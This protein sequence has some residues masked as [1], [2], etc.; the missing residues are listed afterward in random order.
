MSPGAR[1]GGLA[2]GFWAAARD[3]LYPPVCAACGEE[4]GA[5]AA[6][7]PACFRETVFLAPPLC[8]VC[9]A[10]APADGGAG[11]CDACLHAP[12][13][14]DRARAAALYAGPARRAALQLKHGDRLD[15]A[16]AVAP[17]LAR[18]GE[19]ML[20]E[21]DVIA[22]VPLHWTRLA[23]R[24]FNQAAELGRAA[25]RAAG[26]EAAFMPDLL[27]RRR[28]TPSQEG[29]SRAARFENVAGAFAV[30]P[31]HAARLD[32]ARTLLVDDVM[33]TGATLSACAEALKAAGAARVEALALARVARSDHGLYVAEEAVLGGPS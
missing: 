17:W 27:I 21:A 28:V 24:R 16:A 13:A 31:R 9:G 15:I 33:T 25:A 2:A 6:L 4:T 26:R 11:P 19:A 7:C 23:L 29:R 12:P 30:R 3:L 5:P 8:P 20:A 1:G 14:Y 10:P 22:P 18:A 32:G